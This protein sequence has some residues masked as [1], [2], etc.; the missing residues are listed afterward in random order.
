[1]NYGSAQPECYA[2]EA[3]KQ[4]EALVGKKQITLVADTEDKDR[5]GRSLRYMYV[6]TGAGE[7]F[8]NN[9][10]VYSGAAI[11]KRYPPNTLHALQ[12]EASQQKAQAAKLG[13]WAEC[14]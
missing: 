8:V 13:L 10:L 1:M 4:L 11:A 14:K 5:Y 6:T 9:A 7:L 12:L 2:R 3:K